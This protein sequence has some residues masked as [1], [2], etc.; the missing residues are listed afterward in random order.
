MNA[1]ALRLNSRLHDQGEVKSDTVDEKQ[2]WWE[3][4]ESLR[5]ECSTWSGAGGN[6]SLWDNEDSAGSTTVPHTQL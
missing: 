1:V 4:V 6:R 5:V 3:A 2:G